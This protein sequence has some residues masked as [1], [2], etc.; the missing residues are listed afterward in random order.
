[1]RLK[2]L[3]EGQ[4]VKIVK[5]NY[6]GR[7]ATVLGTAGLVGVSAR[8]AV[9]GDERPHRTLRLASLIVANPPVPSPSTTRSNGSATVQS[10][11]RKV[12]EIEKL[13]TS[14]KLDLEEIRSSSVSE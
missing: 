2:D 14:L 8:V 5:G 6:A 12:E 4:R 7:F 11:I 9:E 13:M 3:H 1:M 10:V